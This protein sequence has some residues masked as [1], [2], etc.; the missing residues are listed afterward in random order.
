MLRPFQRPSR[1]SSS[2]AAAM[3]ILV[4]AATGVAFVLLRGAPRPDRMFLLIAAAMLL[5]AILVGWLYGRPVSI[6]SETMSWV[7]SRKAR[8][9]RMDYE[10]SRKPVSFRRFGTKTPPSV[11]QIRD[12]KS[13][14]TNNW[15][16]SQ[17]VAKPSKRH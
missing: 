13:G 17:Q 8:P 4:E 10:L 15:V 6:L 11:D 12:L 9:E 5:L 7:M 16:P 14:T 2:I 3:L 1:Q